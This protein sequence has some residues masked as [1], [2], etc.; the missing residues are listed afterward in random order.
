MPVQNVYPTPIYYSVV[1]NFDVIQEEIKE[2]LVKTSLEMKEGWGNTHYL[3]TTNFQDNYIFDHNLSN[4]FGE[5]VTHVKEYCKEIGCSSSSFEIYQS[6]V[7]LFKKGNYGHIHNHGS[8]DMSG[9]YYH[10][11]NGKDGD[12]FFEPANPFL[13]T[14]DCYRNLSGRFVHP[15]EEGKI[16]LFP[17][18]MKHGILTNTTDN[19]RISISFNIN[20]PRSSIELNE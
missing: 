16:I 3:S 11:T 20:F 4:F 14:S 7:S 15:P 10:K 8:S 12:I 9:V 5:I 18:W 2:S 1:N 6:W 17:G 13:Q 19:T